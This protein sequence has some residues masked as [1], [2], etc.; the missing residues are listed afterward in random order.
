MATNFNKYIYYILICFTAILCACGDCNQIVRGVILDKLTNLPIDSVLITGKN[1]EI[2]EYSDS[3]GSFEAHS[4]SGGIY[5]C[6]LLG[7]GFT[8]EGYQSFTGEYNNARIIKI[9]LQ[10]AKMVR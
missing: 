2:N 3:T 1:G 6:P 9:Y 7:L 5:S 10:K 8:K 4:I